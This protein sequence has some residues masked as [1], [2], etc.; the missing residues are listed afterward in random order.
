MIAS[1]QHIPVNSEVLEKLRAMYE[2]FDDDWSDYCIEGF[3]ENLRQVGFDSVE[4]AFSGFSCQGDG[5][6]F[7]GLWAYKE[8]D[9]AY[10]LCEVTEQFREDIWGVLAHHRKYDFTFELTRPNGQRH[11][12]ERS[13][14]LEVAWASHYREFEPIE[15]WDDYTTELTDVCVGYAQHIYATL[16]DE[17][18][19]YTSD[20]HLWQRIL[21]DA[22]YD[23]E[24]R[25]E[26]FCLLAQHT[27]DTEYEMEKE[28]QEIM[29]EKLSE[30]LAAIT[31]MTPS[32]ETGED[33]LPSHLIIDFSDA[34]RFIQRHGT[35]VDILNTAKEDMARAINTVLAR[36]P[37]PQD[38]E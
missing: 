20:E 11:V 8:P 3:N 12:H 14:Q 1:L 16:Q 15:G 31:G 32:V 17:Y 19:Y 30:K 22:D 18:E 29:V 13:T 27:D 2:T 24:R 4:I 21:D 28:A 10:A 6:S 23:P 7:T 5:A 35:T 25:D 37:V 26:L 9:E 34:A 36:L 33:G 38:P